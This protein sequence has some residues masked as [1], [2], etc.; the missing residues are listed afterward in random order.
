[1]LLA[2]QIHLQKLNL[3]FLWLQIVVPSCGFCCWKLPLLWFFLD[4]LGLCL[5]CSCS[6]FIYSLT[7]LILAETL[8]FA[9]AILF[10]ACCCWISLTIVCCGWSQLTSPFA[11]FVPVAFH[12]LSHLIDPCWATLH[13]ALAILFQ[14]CCCWI[15][16]T[17]VLVCR[18]CPPLI[19]YVIS[20]LY[21]MHTLYGPHMRR[22]HSCTHLVG[23]P[24]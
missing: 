22:S 23:T 24:A 21:L 18:K 16:L 15:S 7:W 4:F 6:L 12:L 8:H 20:L 1:M 10:Q 14:A 5:I 11:W 2:L 13:S 19:M 17:V 9:P 3:S